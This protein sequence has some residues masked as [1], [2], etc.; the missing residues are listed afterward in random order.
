MGVNKQILIGNV[1]KD[2]EMKTLES[3]T[4]LATFTVAT[5]NRRFKDDDGNPRTEWH[6]VV[7][8]GK[9][10][11]IVNSYIR[12]GMTVYLEGETRHRKFEGDD[13]TTRYYTEVHI[14]EM[15][16]LSKKDDRRSEPDDTPY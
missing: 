9:L 13:G 12:K 2:P 11:E 15:E 16:I 5:S 14:A 4:N 3:G 7:A 6:N 10:A 1:G 8:W